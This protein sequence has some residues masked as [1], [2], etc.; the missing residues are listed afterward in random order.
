MTLQQISQKL[1]LNVE[2]TGGNS[3]AQS[4]PSF[5]EPE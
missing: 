5:G 3:A 2:N 4:F 1:L